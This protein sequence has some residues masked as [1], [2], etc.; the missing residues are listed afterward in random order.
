MP[1]TALSPADA[2]DQMQSLI[3]AVG[4][5]LVGKTHAIQLALTCLVAGGHL[6]LED[7]PGVGKTTLALALARLLGLSYQRLQCTSDLLPADVIGV[8]VYDR[9][10][11]NMDGVIKYTGANNDRDPILLNVGSTTPNNVR[12]QQLP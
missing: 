6:L 12:V 8:S 2:R 11:V 7:L 9:R 3:E 4:Q 5:V 1:M 10:D